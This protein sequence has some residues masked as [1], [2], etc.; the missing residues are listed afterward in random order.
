MVFGFVATGRS[1]PIYYL[2][3]KCEA[4]YLPVKCEAYAGEILNHFKEILITLR[5]VK[6]D[7]LETRLSRKTVDDTMSD[8]TINERTQRHMNKYTWKNASSSWEE[9]SY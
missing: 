1:Q 3:V 5:L 8:P 2:P 6:W 9:D 4:Y 7:A